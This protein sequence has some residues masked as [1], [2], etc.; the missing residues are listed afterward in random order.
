MPN[1]H[2]TIFTDQ[3]SSGGFDQTIQVE[4][5]V[6]PANRLKLDCIARSPYQQTIFLDS[7]TYICDDIS[8]LFDIL[9]HFD[10]A[11]THD[12]GYTDKFPTGTGVPSV[13]REFNTGVIVYRKSDGV[14]RL[15]AESIRWYDQLSAG[16]RPIVADQAAFR[17]AAYYS[18]V[19]IATLTFEYNCRFPYFGYA[20]GK[21]KILHGRE[22]LTAHNEAELETV[23]A[24]VNAVLTPRVYVAGEVH[25]L[26][27]SGSP[28]SRR[29]VRRRVAMSFKPYWR[30]CMHLLRESL[31]EHG[32]G[33]TGAWIL[34][35]VS[36]R[37]TKAS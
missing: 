21:V 37:R 29:F 11:L 24:A 2:V 15:F 18:N 23:A 1:I 12:R 6:F 8:D 7:D 32:A 34:R 9:S 30:Y 31:R 22:F 35:T 25:V 3:H 17:I 5:G 4:R 28:L 26:H 16:P 19:R 33:A 20:S 13:F 14:D 36:R 10:M 27:R